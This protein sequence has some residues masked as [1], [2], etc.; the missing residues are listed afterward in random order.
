ML[1]VG[2][3]I[4]FIAELMRLYI[5]DFCV[6]FVV[7][8]SYGY[9]YMKQKIW[10]HFTTFADKLNHFFFTDDFQRIRLSH[11]FEGLYT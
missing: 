1:H 2:Y 7:G 8:I 3:N 5:S 4:R 11:T 6:F 10:L 9:T